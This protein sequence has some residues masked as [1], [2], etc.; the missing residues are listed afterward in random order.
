ML[1]QGISARA[2][3]LEV[4]LCL[5]AEDAD[6]DWRG[7]VD[8]VVRQRPSVAILPHSLTEAFPDSIQPFAA[9][10]IPIIGV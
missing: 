7:L 1:A 3:E 6:E 4:E 9:A 10:G 8:E 5:P 2:A